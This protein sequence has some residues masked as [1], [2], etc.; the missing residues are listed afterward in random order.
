[1]GDVFSQIIVS[2]LVACLVVF[3][4]NALPVSG[5]VFLMT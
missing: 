2:W 1:M 4:K 3:C 5:N